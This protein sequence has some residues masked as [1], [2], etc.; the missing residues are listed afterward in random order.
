MK[1]M[2]KLFLIVAAIIAAIGAVLMIVASCSAKAA[3]VQLFPEKSDGKYVYTVDFTDTDISK[4]SIDATDADITVYTGNEKEYIEFINF[5]ENYYSISTTN[6]VISF[7]EYVDLESVFSFWDS[8][9]KFKGIRSLFSLGKKIDGDKQI[10]IYISDSRDLNVFDF[11][12]EEGIISISNLSTSTDYK[13]TVGTGEVKFKNIKTSSSFSL[14][15]NNCSLELEN[16]EFHSFKVDVADVAMKGGISELHTFALNSKSGSLNTDLSF[17][18]DKI[19]VSATTSGSAVINGETVQPPYKN[20]SDPNE[21]T[22]D[23]STVEITGETLN[24]ILNFEDI[25]TDGA[26]EENQ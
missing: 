20:A 24:V 11:E 6:R 7:D 19:Y 25:G 22:S 23:Y 9:F 17:D 12:I 1:P 2:S 16:C 5:N 13:F 21:I 14:V 10:N 15:G 3:G 18:S 26:K 8:N 4:I